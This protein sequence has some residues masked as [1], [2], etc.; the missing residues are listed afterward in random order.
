MIKGYFVTVSCSN[1]Y[2]F[3]F[4]DQSKSNKVRFLVKLGCW[5]ALISSLLVFSYPILMSVKFTNRGFKIFK[6]YFISIAKLF[7]LK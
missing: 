5:N 4:L 7:I 6:N 2:D 1:L 3:Q